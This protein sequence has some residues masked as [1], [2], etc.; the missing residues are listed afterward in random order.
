MDSCGLFEHLKTAMETSSRVKV[1]WFAESAPTRVSFFLYV[2]D[3]ITTYIYKV[4]KEPTRAD[5]SCH[6]LL[7][8]STSTL[9]DSR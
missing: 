1:V 8:G 2:M 7:G 5:G 4:M 9:R 6:C 3:N